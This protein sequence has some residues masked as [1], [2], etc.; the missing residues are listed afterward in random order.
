MKKTYQG[1]VYPWHCD[2]FSHM[3]VQ[4]YVG[5]FDQSNFN[6]FALVGLT[7]EYFRKNNRGMAA[8]EQHILYKKEVVAGDN[9]FVKSEISI[10]GPKVV[11]CHHFMYNVDHE[12]LVAETTIVAVHLDT[13]K[14]KSVALPEFVHQKIKEL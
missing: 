14:R 5:K 7:S 12:E 11:R 10:A 3:N 13:I 2:H 8:L 1:T 9:I 4:Y 6:T